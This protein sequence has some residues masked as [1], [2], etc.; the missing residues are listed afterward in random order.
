[1][2]DHTRAQVISIKMFVDAESWDQLEAAIPGEVIILTNLVSVF[3]ARRDINGGMKANL[4]SIIVWFGPC[5]LCSLLYISPCFQDSKFSHLVSSNQ[6]RVFPGDAAL[7]SRFGHNEVVRAFRDLE[8]FTSVLSQQGGF[9]GQ[10]CQG[11]FVLRDLTAISY[12]FRVGVK[13]V[14]PADGCFLQINISR[15]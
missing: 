11:P 5:L 3:Q 14:R 13:Q 15:E 8:S 12:G 1:M 6:T 7:K 9:G 10:F 2:M 4:Q